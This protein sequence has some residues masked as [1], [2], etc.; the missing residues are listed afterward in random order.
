VLPHEPL[1]ELESNLWRVSGSLPG[2][3]PLRRVMTVARLARGGL[4]VHSPIA[5]DAAAMATLDGLGEVRFVV[6]PNA[7]HRLD[8]SSYA[9]RYPDARVLAPRGARAKVERLVVVHGGLA[10]LGDR[11]VE[12]DHVAGTHEA[13]A[14][15]TVRSGDWRSLV[16]TDT[17]FNMPHQPGV[18]G[19]V[20]KH[21]TQSSGGP[22]VS[23]LAKLFMIKDAAAFSA[24]LDAL[25]AQPIARVIVS[26]HD[27][28]IDDPAGTL[29]RIAASLGAA[30]TPSR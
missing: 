18:S 1:E 16:F 5:L 20:L 22:R 10:D 11:D 24:Q 17:V 3:I 21:V 6:V 25:A 19:W 8:A 9:M 26:H 28:I 27:M 29:K 23:R 14:L 13:E 4:V 12:L 15:M 2:R 30:T 7:Q